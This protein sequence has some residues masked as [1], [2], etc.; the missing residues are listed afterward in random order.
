MKRI[1]ILLFAKK[2]LWTKEKTYSIIVINGQ[3]TAE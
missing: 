1:S 2:C 3:R